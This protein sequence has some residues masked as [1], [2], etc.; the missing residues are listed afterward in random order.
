M[1]A[2]ARRRGALLEPCV[3]TAGRP[4]A[5]VAPPRQCAR[6][7]TDRRTNHS[8]PFYTH[9]HTHPPA[10]QGR[11]DE[12]VEQAGVKVLIDPGALMHVLGTRMDYVEDRLR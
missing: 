2:T 10:A 12:L 9:T 4:A 11:F 6:R 5:L 7:A 1:H 3:G 8:H